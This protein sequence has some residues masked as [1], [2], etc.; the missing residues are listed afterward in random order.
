VQHHDLIFVNQVNG[1]DEWWTL[2]INGDQLVPFESI[3]FRH[4]IAR[5]EFPSFIQRLRVASVEQCKNL[6]Y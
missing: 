3:T 6:A 2:K 5:G 4:I 1:G